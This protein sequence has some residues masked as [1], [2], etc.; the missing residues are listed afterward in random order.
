MN[1]ETLEKMRRMKLYGMHRVFKTSLETPGQELLTTDEMVAQLIESE[2]ED[3]H[4]RAIERGVKNARFRYRAN[5]EQLDYSPDR[6]IDR[7]QLHR[8]A[9]GEYIRRGE[10]LLITGST[11][12]GKSYVASALGQQACQQGFKVLYA[13]A[14][15]L[16]TL[17]KIAKADGTGIRELLKI[18]KQNL[19]ILDD[20]GIQPLDAVSRGCLMEI[21]EDRHAKS[22]TI[23]TSQLPVRQWYDVIGEKTV[24]DAIM[25]R[26]VSNAQRIDLKGE[27]LRKKP[28]RKEEVDEE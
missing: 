17:L 6:G 22:S 4:N 21:I 7:N 10:N 19:L 16:F 11:G 25:D 1:N 18:E 14:S 9:E 13:G 23:I 26:I 12:T 27:S 15:R 2:W 5:I 8:L 20:F 3:R 28:A 24:A